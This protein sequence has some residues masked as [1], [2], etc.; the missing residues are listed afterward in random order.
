M[1]AVLYRLWVYEYLAQ[2]FDGALQHLPEPP[3]AGGSP[4]RL[5]AA[6]D[7]LLTAVVQ[8]PAEEA[9]ADHARLFVSARDGIAAPPYASWYLDR[10]LLGPSSM[11]VERAYADQGVERAPDAGEP[12]DYIAAELEFLIFLTRHELAARRTTD[13]DALRGVLDSE[14]QFVLSHF[15]R[16]LPAFI[17]HIRAAEPGPVFAAAT[18]LLSAV[19]EDDVSRLSTHRSKP[20]ASR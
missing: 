12:P 20:V 8:S 19:M 9:L 7:R 1:T 4:S 5:S 6:A 2:L 15:A 17:A 16:W 13:T 18:D 14:K 3:D 10:Q 11:W